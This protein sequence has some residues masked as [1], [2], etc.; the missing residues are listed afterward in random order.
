VNS[1][2]RSLPSI[3]KLLQDPRLKD[4]ISNHSH[5]PIVALA[6][7]ALDAAR[8]EILDGGASPDHAQIIAG[9]ELAAAAMLTSWPERVINATGVVIH[10]NLGRA[11]LSGAATKAAAATAAGYTDLEISLDTGKRGSRTEHISR[12]LAQATGAEAGLVVNNNAS[13][14]MLALANFCVD[15][16]VIVSRGEAVEIGGGFRIPDVLGQSGAILV[17]VGTT[18]R[19]YARDYENAITDR[20]AAILKVH[21]SNFRVSGFTA[22][23]SAQ[24]LT[25]VGNRRGVLVINDLGSGCMLDTAQFGMMPEPTVQESVDAGIGLSMFSGDKLLGGPQAGIIVGNENLIGKMAKH[26]L[27]RALRVDKI[28]LATLS[29]TLLS[30]INGSAMEDI[31]VWRMIS[32]S[33][34]SLAARLDGWLSAS[35]GLGEIATLEESRSAIGGGSLPGETLPTVVVSITPPGAP[36]DMLATLRARTPPVIARIE[37]DKILLDPR[38]VLPEED[39][40]VV[41]ALSALGASSESGEE[42]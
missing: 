18:N 29:A 12:L 13:A 11:P 8:S 22:A 3:E 39:G 21:P 10:T 42:R 36:D 40:A 35:P 41:N 33:Q 32:A 15:G 31:P 25:E 30:Y 38:T 9:I 34:E 2:L 26:P 17:E 28:T 14:V 37:D 4:V 20:T 16:E 5:A 6:R 27:M 24:E 19:T 1:N 7:T 23:P